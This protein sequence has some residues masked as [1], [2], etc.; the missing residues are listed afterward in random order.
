MLRAQF[1]G[2]ASSRPTVRRNV[3]AIALQREGD[4]Y[5]LDCGEGTQ[6]Q[7]MRFGTGFTVRA[8]FVTHL[9]ADHYLGITGLVRTM[10]LQ[11]RREP[12]ELWGPPGSSE[13]LRT[14]VELGGDRSTFP[15]EI[16][17]LGG[18]E[19]V[20][21]QGY[22]IEAFDTPHSNRS[23]GY[24]LVED[25]RAGRFDVERAREL[26]VPEGPMF[27]R[28][29]RGEAVTLDDGEVVEPAQVVGPPRP[30]R[31]IVYTGDTP[32]CEPV[33]EAA[34]EADLLIHEAT[35]SSDEVERA[36][37]TGHSTALQAAKVAR[38]AGARRLVLTHLSARYSEQ[39]G[40]LVREAREVFRPVTV[41]RDGTVVEVP[42]PDATDE[43]GAR[44]GAGGS[45][46]EAGVRGSD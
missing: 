46:R 26:G 30:G 24:R 23:V 40:T 17:E 1:L 35:F 11:G 7:M 3:P 41:A 37:A 5:L 16:G 25:D 6:R 42:Y 44:R 4:L 22:R 15:V 34:R 19:S 36:R 10:S 31:R 8:L 27:G 29:H 43:D 12:L 28:L 9:H 32:P 20:P 33:V 13:T 18:G 45:D 39:P 14:V 2:T 38:R 21:L